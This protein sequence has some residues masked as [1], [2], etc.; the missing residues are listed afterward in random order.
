M[1]ATR[2]F[3]K[4]S[5]ALL[6]A[7]TA[8]ATQARATTLTPT[9][10]VTI[11]SGQVQ[12]AIIGGVNNFL[13]IPYAAPPVGALRWVAPQPAAS[14]TGVRQT[15]AYGNYC[16]QGFSQIGVGGGDEDCL[17]ISVQA[18]AGATASSNLPVLF[19]IHGGGLQT[20]SAQEY[21][22]SAMV[23][24]GNVVYVA[25]NYR[26]GALGFLAHAA[27]TA[28]D[29]NH[30]SGNYGLLDQQAG[31]A[32]VRANIKKFGG[33]PNSITIF[34]E[35]AGGLSV[36]SQLVSPRVGKLRAAIIESGG[37]SQTYQTLAAAE[38][39]GA[40]NAVALGCPNG[41]TQLACLRSVAATAVVKAEATLPSRA[42]GSPNIDN[43][44]LTEQPFQA[45]LDGHFAHVPI[46]NGT[47]H[48][49]GRLFVSESELLGGSPYTADSFTAALSAITPTA[50]A[51]YP[52]TSYDSPNYAYAAASTDYTFSCPAYILS[53]LASQWTPV[54]SYEL[55]DPHWPNKFLPPDPNLPDIGNPHAAELTYLYPQYSVPFLN[56]GPANA[57]FTPAQQSLASYMRSAWTSL[58][59]YGRP[60]SPRGGA[61]PAYSPAQVNVLSLA[62]PS[63]VLNT[64]FKTFH[65]CDF[66]TPFLLNKA[67]LP[68]GSVN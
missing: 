7:G 22:G 26:L 41:A 52:L 34:G 43:Y 5:A 68:A 25:L 21:D 54:Y 45:F 15:T 23:R 16:P 30:R 19:W 50:L 4:F 28:E 8:L 53:A 40:Q 66:W 32:W 42:S 65:K 20:G 24:Q 51:Q 62:P 56:Y 10:V 48:D 13:G 58:A 59:R 18:P 64:S 38:T 27:L 57:L 39:G 49:E 35:S 12:G 44:I 63:P 46:I 31:L 3:L 1:V 17:T 29:P 47:N 2:G 9:P 33:N 36:I 37:Y 11:A 67:G 6:L 61:W 60:L 55:A 14:W